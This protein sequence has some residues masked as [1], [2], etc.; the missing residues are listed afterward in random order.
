[1]SRADTLASNDQKVQDHVL[2]GEASEAEITAGD[3]ESKHWISVR[4]FVKALK[5]MAT[6]S[7]DDRSKSGANTEF[8]RNQIESPNQSF[9]TQVF[10]KNRLINGNFD[11][12]Q[13]GA[14]GT[15]GNAVGPAQSVYGPDRWII[16]MPANANATWERLVFA[17]G[18]GVNESRYA[19]RV[20]RSG[21]GDGVNISQRIEG[22][23]CFAGKKVTLSFYARASIN[24]VCAVICRQNLGAG[25]SD[26]GPG[27]GAEI[28]L[29]TDYKKYTVTLDVPSIAGKTRGSSGDYLEVVFGSAGKG[30]YTFDIASVQAEQ[31]AVATEYEIRPVAHE[32]ML[33]QRYFE[34]TFPQDVAPSIDSGLSGTLVGLVYQNQAGSASQPVAHWQFK[35]EKRAT[36]SI[37][38]YRHGGN[39]G[40]NQWTNS[41]GESSTVNASASG[42]CS[43][44]ATIG[45]SDIGVPATTYYIH[46]SADAEL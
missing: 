33:C 4:R 31:G 43:R 12:W 36:P 9:P 30:G 26:A 17:P 11:I 28:S 23:E 18:T 34:K 24:H 22:A 41:S 2:Q 19:L 14:T 37:R 8:V 39:A 15:A 13:R 44:S 38:L 5:S 20:T 40:A 32:L 7:V 29:T 35:V 46:A 27:V 3:T 25:G 42:V 21:T 16:Y 10:R 45:N 6:A 1:M